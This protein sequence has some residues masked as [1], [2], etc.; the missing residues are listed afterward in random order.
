MERVIGIDLGTTNSCVAI[1]E[2]GVPTVIPNRGG[3]KTTPSM[4]AI[5]EAGKRLV[6]HIA[7]R[8]AITN[9]EN[10]VYAA[11]RLI[12]R[13]YSSSQVKH[14]MLSASYRIVEG[15][16][17][18]VRIQ[19]RD[20]TYSVP[21][22]SAMVLQE[23]KLFA[24]D[25]LSE[26]VTKAVITV[27]AYFNDGQ[28]QATKD[29]GQIA[30]LDVI[31]IVNEPTAAALAY[32]FERNVEK[33]IAVFDLGGG[34]FDI[35]ILEIG[36]GGVFKVIATAGDTFL[37]GEDFDA[38]II[39]WLVQGFRDQTGVDLRQD[40]M[41]LQRL[42]DAA[43]KAKCELSGV[44][45]TE[46]N[47]PFIISSGRNEALHLQRTLT[48][49]SMEKLCGDLVDRCIEICRQTL[50]DARI[51]REEIEDVIL[52]GGMT[53]MP[54]VQDAVRQFFGREPCKGVHPDEVVALGAA[55]QGA[56]LVD[57][58]KQMVLLDVTPH[59]LGIMTH[60]SNFD[61][62]IPMNTTVPTSRSKIFT[63]SRDNQTAVKILVMQGE[64]AQ[65]EGNE[66]LGEFVLTGLR[67]APKGQVEIEVTFAID[68]DGIVS[69]GAKDL[70]TGQQQSIQV[71]ASSGLTKE[72]VGAMMEAAK[73]YLVERRSNDE[74]EGVK[75]E[76]EKVIA[77]IEKMF[78]KVQAIVQSSDFGRDAIEKARA[79]LERC[80]EAIA[81][82]DLT[83][84]R[85][86]MDSLARTH[87]MFKGV[88]ARP[89]G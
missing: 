61:E 62:L 79:I 3:Y 55:V 75:Q 89:Q 43:E 54:R 22:I 53:R 59:A 66:L 39:D 40:R 83:A 45:E 42:K 1:V 77:D 24:E 78:P 51:E 17:G 37:G 85:G 49:D 68:S 41:A 4:V 16:H 2:D 35:S 48:R 18:D 86:Q 7:K 60:G 11:K 5:T 81:R 73:E 76:A 67:R 70:E 34:T 57:E 65:A 74:F 58:S 25:Y 80:R 63:T 13:K 27:P 56:A 82:K 19:L 10:T 47:L 28:R 30:G 9:A 38:R 46:I 87:R 32:G 84:L 31:R 6:G 33:T 64:S 26:P 15:P 29:A 12:G 20:K 14:A 36:A 21:E 72:E 52:V 44:R 88:I 50:E 23:M 69:V 8:Q 71:T